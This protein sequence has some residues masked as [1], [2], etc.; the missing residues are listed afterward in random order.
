MSIFET[1]NFQ[2]D[3][4]KKIH[5]DIIKLKNIREDIEKCKDNLKN[6]EIIFDILDAQIQRNIQII[7]KLE[8]LEDIP[9]ICHIADNEI[10]LETIQYSHRY[11][12]C[13]NAAIDVFG[14]LKNTLPDLSQ[15]EEVQKNDSKEYETLNREQ[16]L[17]M[18]DLYKDIKTDL[19]KKSLF[20]Q[21]FFEELYLMFYISQYQI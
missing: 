5:L 20:I 15:H 18:I 14:V 10:I 19:S 16:I 13:K 1:L 11:D 9:L 8:L 2:S 3:T 6:N 4:I 17:E 21:V 12:N 7:A